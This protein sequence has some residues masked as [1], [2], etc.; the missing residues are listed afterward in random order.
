MVKKHV[1]K[2]AEN[3]AQRKYHFSAM[4]W[5]LSSDLFSVC[6]DELTRKK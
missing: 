2:A 5:S 6:K 3:T 4:A 1:L